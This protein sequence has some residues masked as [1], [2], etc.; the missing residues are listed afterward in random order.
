MHA[1]AERAIAWTQTQLTAPQIS[2][3]EKLPL[4]VRREN[5]YFVNGSAEAPADWIYVTDPTRAW[6][7]LEAAGTSY[8]F[9]GHVHEPVLYYTGAA[10]RPVPFH[11]VS[12]VPIPVPPRR[13]WLA[14]VG[15]TGQP[16]DGNT[17]ACYAILDC[18]RSTLTYFRVPYDWPAAAAK[19][20]SAGLPERFATRLGRGE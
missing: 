5:Q 3:L 13:R 9:S 2:F 12:V 6:H 8:V 11:P 18:K 20:L 15:S 7:S 10:Q 14:I 16:R 1:A 4:V 19:I 17:A